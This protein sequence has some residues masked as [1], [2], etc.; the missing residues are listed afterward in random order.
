MDYDT[1]ES[2]IHTSGVT[3]KAARDI[4][5]VSHDKVR[6]IIGT[7]KLRHLTTEP[8]T[9]NLSVRLEENVKPAAIEF[10]KALIENLKKFNSRRFDIFF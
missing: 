7:Q 2:L 1:F 4:L 6:V 9:F 3:G 5:G 8:F 10:L